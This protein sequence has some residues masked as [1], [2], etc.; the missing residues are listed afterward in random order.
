MPTV[1]CYLP[2]S[3][4]RTP[5]HVRTPISL[6]PSATSLLVGESPIRPQTAFSGPEIHVTSLCWADLTAG[7]RTRDGLDPQQSEKTAINEWLRRNARN[8]MRV[9]RIP[10]PLPFGCTRDGHL[11]MNWFAATCTK[12]VTRHRTW[13][14]EPI[15]S[16]ELGIDHEMRRM[17]WKKVRTCS[18]SGDARAQEC[19]MG[20][21]EIDRFVEKPIKAIRQSDDSG[22]ESSNNKY[23][24]W[25]QS[26]RNISQR[27][28]RVSHAIYSRFVSTTH[29]FEVP[30]KFHPF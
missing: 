22:G 29:R 4:S 10:S 3:Q 2:V 30:I 15:V 6:P 24:Y 25:W 23:T 11:E 7:A 27:I 20:R 12:V 17:R 26:F 18:K 21:C 16:I 19:W 9:N 1:A 5:P 13:R 14:A 28:H 8:D